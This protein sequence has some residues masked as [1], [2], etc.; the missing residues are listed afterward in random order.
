MRFTVIASTLFTTIA[1]VAADFH[2]GYVG[3]AV[4][5]ATNRFATL[6]PASQTSCLAAYDFWP[7]GPYGFNNLTTD[8]QIQICGREIVL[9]PVT[10]AWYTHGREIEQGQCDPVNGGAGTVTEPCQTAPFQSAARY[11]D[12]WSCKSAICSGTDAEGACCDGPAPA[13]PATGSKKR[14]LE[15]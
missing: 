6:L 1:F 10:G 4:T 9:N 8:L 14:A 7:R 12:I 13:A 11:T 5:T 3:Y 2:F 15:F